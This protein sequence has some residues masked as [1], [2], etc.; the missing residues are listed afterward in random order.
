MGCCFHGL[1]IIWRWQ[2]DGRY[3][4]FLNVEKEFVAIVDFYV[5]NEPPAVSRDALHVDFY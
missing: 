1:T 5:L 3:M 2:V 4:G